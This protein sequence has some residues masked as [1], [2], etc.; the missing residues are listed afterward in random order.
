MVWNTD[1]IETLELQNIMDNALITM[2]SACARQESRGA[3]AREDY[4]ERDDDTWMKHTVGW[5]DSKGKVSLDYR[6]VG[7]TVAEPGNEVVP[8]A[9]RVY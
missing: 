8:P 1:L 3:H 6:P 4:P 7:M 9:K 5:I 2:Y